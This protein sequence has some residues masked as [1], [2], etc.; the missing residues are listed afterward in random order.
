MSKK[1]SIQCKTCK[2]KIYCVECD[3]IIHK[4][5]KFSDHERS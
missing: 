4:S 3:H 2:N 1:A 5:S